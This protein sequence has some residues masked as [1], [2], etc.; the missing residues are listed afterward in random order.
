MRGAE[1]SFGVRISAP[2][3]APPLSSSAFPLPHPALAVAGRRQERQRE[4][5]QP[6]IEGLL[7]ARAQAHA[8]LLF[9]E[10]PPKSS[11]G[12]CVQGESRQVK[13]RHC[14]CRSG[15]CSAFPEGGQAPGQLAVGDSGW[16]PVSGPRPAPH[17]VVLVSPVGAQCFSEPASTLPAAAARGGGHAEA[18]EEASG[19]EHPVAEIAKGGV[20]VPAAPWR[21]RI[22]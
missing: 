7:S 6:F 1:G 20:A 5:R 15:G 9:Y 8:S 11:A 14:A 21:P 22:R 3:T 2:L 18:R 17:H 13:E 19:P 4:E 16:H 12:I 10:G